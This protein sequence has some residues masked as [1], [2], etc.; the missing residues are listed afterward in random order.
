M[1]RLI[2]LAAVAAVSL[3]LSFRAQAQLGIVGGITSSKTTLESAASDVKNISL[4][5]AGLTYKIGLGAGFAVQPSVIYQVKG[6]SLGNLDTASDVDFKLKSGFVEVPVGLQWGPDLLV[7]RPYVFAEPFIGYQVT[8]SDRGTANF[9][10]WAERTKN[11]LEYGM[12]LGGGIEIA[13]HLQFSVQWFRNLGPVFGENAPSAEAAWTS[14]K[15]IR[16]YQG[17][18]M[19]L[20]ILF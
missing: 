7:F 1:K 15:D 10:D 18:K 20:G 19:T 5:H 12:G 9:S 4:Y 13:G 8:S 2:T 11:R 3:S 14:I 16:N 17:I 6:A